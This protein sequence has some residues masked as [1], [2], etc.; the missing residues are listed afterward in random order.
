MEMTKHELEQELSLV[1]DE[2]NFY[3]YL[4]D[5]ISHGWNL[6]VLDRLEHATQAY[7]RIS[8]YYD[9]EVLKRLVA[10]YRS[11]IFGGNPAKEI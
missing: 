1:K 10:I 11:K 9:G 8:T 5:E 3:L 4:L 7:Y 6:S 2:R